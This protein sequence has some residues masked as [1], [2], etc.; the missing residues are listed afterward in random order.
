MILRL[1]SPAARGPLV[2]LALIFGA[3]LRY[4]LPVYDAER[5]T[6]PGPGLHSIGD[7]VVSTA[8]TDDI[9]GTRQW[10]RIER[11]G[12]SAKDVRERRLSV[13]APSAKFDSKMGGSASLDDMVLVPQ[14]GEHPQR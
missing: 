1:S 3:G 2:L 5:N 6:P 4:S 10:T 9:P 14:S 8:C 11:P 12:N 7:S 13:G